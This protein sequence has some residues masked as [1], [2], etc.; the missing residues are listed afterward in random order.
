MQQK[1]PTIFCFTPN[2]WDY[3]WWVDKQHLLSRL[4][5]KGW[6]VVYSNGPLDVWGRGNR[7]WQRAGIF[8]RTEIEPLGGSA[9]VL[10][11]RPGL[12]LVTWPKLPSWTHFV[13][14]RHVARLLDR[15]GNPPPDRRIA[16]VCHP[17]FRDHA[18]ALGARWLYFHIHD[19]WQDNKGWSAENQAKLESLVEEADLI[20][21]LS[22]SMVK[23]LPGPGR[24]RARVL[25]HGVIANEI[26]AGLNKPCPAD[27]AAIPH[28]RIGYFGRLSRK[29]D[30]EL[31]A[32]LAERRP[33]W[34]FVFVGTVIGLEESESDSAAWARCEKCDN[35]HLL[36]FK[37][38]E[39]VPAYLCH[40]DV[41]LLPF[42]SKGEGYWNSVFSLKTYEYLATG[43]PVVGASIEHIRSHSD[44][45][46]V[47]TSPEEW[48]AAIEQAVQSGGR[49]TPEERQALALEN[50]WDGRADQLD[51]W[52]SHTIEAG[53]DRQAQ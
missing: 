25:P 21:A 44:V 7:A 52:L 6:P 13:V 14:K 40:M 17:S 9:S 36:G 26:M 16:M 49:G 11:D 38:T 30:I 22:D 12:S 10:L 8:S 32:E 47:A 34:H 35:V 20:T 24:E 39:D 42:K 50:S 23:G 4:A 37:E 51:D 28:P 41:N 18:R 46:A 31:L 29:I 45:I 1:R 53:G 19:A 5:A 48:I 43:K 2:Y 3:P 15:A 27:L 33:D